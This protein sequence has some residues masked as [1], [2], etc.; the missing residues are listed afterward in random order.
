MLICSAW[1]NARE[2]GDQPKSAIQK[3]C[4]TPSTNL[5]YT[6][7]TGVKEQSVSDAERMFSHQ[8]AIYMESKGYKE[9]KFIKVVADWRAACDQRGLSELE[10]GKFNCGLLR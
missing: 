2:K 9:A 8:L 5:T 10:R 3:L 1:L 4:M 6:S 7:L